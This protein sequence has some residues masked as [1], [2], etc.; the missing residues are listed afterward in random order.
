MSESVEIPLIKDGVACGVIN[1]RKLRRLIESTYS[2]NEAA[3]YIGLEQRDGVETG[4]IES[5]EY[6]R[7]TLEVWR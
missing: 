7:S 3:F 5:L 6:F 4:V 1:R 2:Q